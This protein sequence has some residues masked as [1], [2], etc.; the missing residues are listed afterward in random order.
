KDMFDLI[1]NIP[2]GTKT[3]TGEST[4]GQLIRQAAIDTGTTLVT[5][6]NIAQSLLD[7][8]AQRTDVV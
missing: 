3:T 7:K 2:T 4:D 5:D 8:L 6:M 1:I